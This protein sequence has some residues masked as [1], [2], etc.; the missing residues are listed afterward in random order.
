MTDQ[1]E[2]TSSAPVDQKGTTHKKAQKKTAGQP[3]S[4]KLI[5]QN[6]ELLGKLAAQMEEA[7][8]LVHK[9]QEARLKEV[10]GEI[11]AATK[12]YND[13][14]SPLNDELAALE[15][16]LGLV[17]EIEVPSLVDGSA[18]ANGKPQIRFDA[19]GK[20]PKALSEPTSQKDP[21]PLCTPEFWNQLMVWPG[22]SDQAT[23]TSLDT[24]LA[25]VIYNANGQ[26]VNTP[27]AMEA[28]K[29][30]GHDTTS[31]TFR[32]SVSTSYGR[33]KS[34]GYIEPVSR[35]CYVIKPKGRK[36][37]ES[38]VAA[39]EASL[40]EGA[41]E[42][43]DQSLDDSIL[44]A[45]KE[46]GKI[47]T[48]RIASSLAKVGFKFPEGSNPQEAVGESLTRLRAEKVI[49]VEKAPGEKFPELS[50]TDAGVERAEALAG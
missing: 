46:N 26:P 41:T 9:G 35:G 43:S 20:M 50:L 8:K 25:L 33:L 39:N 13:T 2:T 42:G 27:T 37:V 10:K 36:Y 44:L 22:K 14:L 29:A 21:A 28:V 34:E 6:Q 12:Q 31:K 5:A 1:V 4:V 32:T 19:F 40:A 38:V 17:A 16:A 3:Q 15:Q 18:N 30:M 45:L 49:V 24:F 11:A 23:M 7:Q 48:T 47:S